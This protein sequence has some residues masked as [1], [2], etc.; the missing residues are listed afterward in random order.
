MIKK[1]KNDGKLGD[2]KEIL[3]DIHK[4]EV[5]L[6]HILQHKYSKLP[7]IFSQVK[8]YCLSAV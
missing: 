3:N 2:P 5:G 8:I 6:G 4:Y 7:V 1:A